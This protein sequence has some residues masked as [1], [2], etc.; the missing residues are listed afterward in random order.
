MPS[1]NSLDAST[2]ISAWQIRFWQRHRSPLRI[3]TIVPPP[4]SK[5]G[6]APM[7]RTCSSDAM[8]SEERFVGQ[9]LDL[10]K[11]TDAT[12]LHGGKSIRL[13]P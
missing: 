6:L 3:S 11:A 2:R 12:H 8:K 9:A 5:F 7:R 10:R 13:R 1:G 4:F